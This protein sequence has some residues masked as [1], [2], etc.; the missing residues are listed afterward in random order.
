VLVLRALRQPR[1]KGDSL[2]PVRMRAA[3]AALALAAAATSYVF[4]A[5][6][7]QNTAHHAYEKFLFRTTEEDIRQRKLRE[8]ML[9]MIPPDAKVTASERLVPHLSNRPDAYTIH[10][11][12]YDAEYVFFKF[13]P[14]DVHPEEPPVVRRLLSSGEFGVLE[15][16]EPFALLKRGYCTEQN[17]RLLRRL[18]QDR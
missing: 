14:P 13:G 3:L 18:G 15:I 17:E 2:G 1:Y 10:A 16:R 6:L 11:G 9:R 5:V 12:V 7:Q 4:G 8:E